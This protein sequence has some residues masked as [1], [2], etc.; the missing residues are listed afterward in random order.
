MSEMNTGKKRTD[1]LRGYFG[2]IGTREL[3][4]LKGRPNTPQ[5]EHDHIGDLAGGIEN[6]TLTYPAFAPVAS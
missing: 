5:A 2:E 6:G 1:V 4:E 3:L